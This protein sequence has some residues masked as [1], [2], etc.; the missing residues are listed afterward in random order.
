MGRRG[1]ERDQKAKG[2]GKRLHPSA[3]N[4]QPCLPGRVQPR[5]ER[6]LGAITRSDKTTLTPRLN[7]FRSFGD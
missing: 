4:L 5:M 7:P 3:F 6:M 1:G 2:K